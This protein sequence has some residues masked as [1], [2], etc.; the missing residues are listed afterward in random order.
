MQHFSFWF[1]LNLECDIVQLNEGENERGSSSVTNNA[2][3]RG[4]DGLYPDVRMNGIPKLYINS[5]GN[6]VSTN[7][8][9]IYNG[10]QVTVTEQILGGYRKGAKGNRPYTSFT[11]LMI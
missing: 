4:D 7:S 5:D 9:G 1:C 2:L 11:L 3:L 8:D 6:L 10:R